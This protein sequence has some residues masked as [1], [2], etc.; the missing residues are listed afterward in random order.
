MSHT[1]LKPGNIITSMVGAD[2]RGLEA[3]VTDLGGAIFNNEC[4]LRLISVCYKAK[5]CM[6][7]RIG[8]K[9]L[10]IVVCA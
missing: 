10:G 4:E 8:S 5:C 1:D 9:A 2:L 3:T 6:H 7:C